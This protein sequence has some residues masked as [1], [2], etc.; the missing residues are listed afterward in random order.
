MEDKH[1]IQIPADIVAQVKSLVQQAIALLFSYVNL[2]LLPRIAYYDRFN[3]SIIKKNEAKSLL[4][5][6]LN[7]SGFLNLT[8][9]IKSENFSN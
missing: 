9:K 4:N 1:A 6:P 7:V 3:L 2:R 8:W 5:F